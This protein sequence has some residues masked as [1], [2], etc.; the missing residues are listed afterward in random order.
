MVNGQHQSANHRCQMLGVA[1]LKGHGYLESLVEDLLP[2]SI[3]TAEKWRILHEYHFGGY[4]KRP[5][6]LIQWCETFSQHHDIPLEPVY[7]GKVFYALWQQILTDKFA[8]GSKILVL[9]TGGLQ[10]AR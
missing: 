5:P 9:H 4:G 8:P 1:V 7:S 2:D 6:E 10:G 3:A